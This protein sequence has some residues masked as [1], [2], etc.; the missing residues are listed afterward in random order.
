V[1]SNVVVRLSDCRVVL[2]ER[3]VLDRLSVDVGRGQFIALL[4]ANGSGKTTLV[5]TM[6]GLVP[7]QSGSVELFDT[8]LE[9]FRNWEKIGY[10]PQRFGAS[11]SIPATVEEIVLTGRIPLTGRRFSY[12][13]KDRAAAARA[14]ESVGLA[15]LRRSRVSTLSGGQQQRALI[16]RALVNG[17]ELFVLDEPVANVD[18][19]YQKSF[20]EM[21]GELPGTNTVLLL[22]HSVGVMRQLVDRTIVLDRGQI[23]YD[24]PPRAEHMR[25]EEHHHFEGHL[26][27]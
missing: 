2:G 20:A 7:R 9:R 26:G 21:L 10:V 18:L 17:P 23:V 25:V 14:L 19:A 13:A 24:G 6:L 16:A 11:A 8:P 22:A 4:G 27:R 1:S 5:R 15:E 3:T 12:S